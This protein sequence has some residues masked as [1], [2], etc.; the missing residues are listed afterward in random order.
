MTTSPSQ[1]SLSIDFYQFTKPPNGPSP[2]GFCQKLEAYFRAVN[3][4]DY[5]LKDAFPFS[6]PKKKLPYV[7][8]HKDGKTDTVADSH[9]IIKHLITSKLLPD[10]DEGLTPAQRADTR[11]WQAWTEERNYPAIVHIRWMRPANYT[12]MKNSMPVPWVL[13]P[14]LGTYFYRLIEDALWKQGVGRHS[15]QEIDELLKEYVDALEAR[16]GKSGFFH[17]VE[18]TMADIIV[19]GFLANAL[20]EAGNPEYTKM[21]LASERIRNYTAELTRR[22]FPEYEEILEVVE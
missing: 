21:L 13:K 8:I 22:W 1:S 11:A 4:K 16:L 10:P 6:A 14:V 15:D 19:Y 3:F 12:A 18:P 17:G 20:G 9:F 5:T 7:Q 2:S